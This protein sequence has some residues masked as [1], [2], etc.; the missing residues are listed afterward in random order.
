MPPMQRWKRDLSRFT[1]LHPL[2]IV[3]GFFSAITFWYLFFLSAK[4]ASL[5][6]TS[7]VLRLACRLYLI[8]VAVVIIRYINYPRVRH[9]EPPHWKIPYFD[10]WETQLNTTQPQ[11]R[12]YYTYIW[13]HWHEM[14]ERIL[15]F[16]T[17]RNIF[18]GI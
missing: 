14:E 8:Y 6:V 18:F 4:W 1:S 3:L 9:P 5:I 13:I 15:F 10:I 7:R 17:A 11:Y 12:S 2:I 16:L